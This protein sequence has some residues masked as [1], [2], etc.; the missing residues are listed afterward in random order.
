MLHHVMN[1]ASLRAALDPLRMP[2]RTAEDSTAGNLRLGRLPLLRLSPRAEASSW[3]KQ[4]QAA[5][6]GY[7]G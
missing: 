3:L 5:G 7:E 2:A 4:G 6:V 1:D